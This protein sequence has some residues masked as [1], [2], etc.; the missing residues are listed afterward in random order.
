MKKFTS[1]LLAG[2][3][4]LGLAACSNNSSSSKEEEKD[5]GTHKVEAKN[6][7][8][9]IPNKLNK[10]VVQNYSDEAVT[11]GQNVIG[12][13]TYAYANPHLPK[14]ATEK[15]KDLGAP[16]N[17]EKI[18]EDKPDLI[19]TMDEDQV[20]N[21][22]KIAPTILLDYNDKAFKDI[23]SRL[24]YFSKLFNAEDK[25]DEF[26]KEFDATAKKETARLTDKGI[27]PSKST[28][29][30]IELSG[31]KIYSYGS[32]FGRG[33]QVLTRGLGFKQSKEMQEI[34][35]AGGF[36]EVNVESLANLSADYIFIDFK[37]TDKSQYEAL[38][39]NPVW[40]KIKAVQ[41]KKVVQMDFDQVYYFAGPTATEKLLPVYV[42]A[43]LDQTNK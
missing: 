27:D 34:T 23:D 24:E 31:N 22:K 25:K 3:V 43:I 21:Y 7:T 42:D 40:Q 39:K 13:D 8:I 6:G 30:I 41:D 5:T 12:T 18:A 37:N 19:I 15:I 2:V 38:T 26:L 28:V 10:I 33:G 36:K 1:L 4:I 16:M 32:N 14:E 20:D 17:A 35:D 11:L 9:E 29:A